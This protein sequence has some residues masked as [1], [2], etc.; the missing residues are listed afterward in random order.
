MACFKSTHVL[1]NKEGSFKETYMQEIIETPYR[2][3][4]LPYFAASPIIKTR[5]Y[6]FIFI[7]NVL[8][9]SNPKSWYQSRI[10]RISRGFVRGSTTLC[11]P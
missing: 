2:M 4:L 10:S 7:K 6:V 5:E 11:Q 3:Y 9:T 1:S 8:L